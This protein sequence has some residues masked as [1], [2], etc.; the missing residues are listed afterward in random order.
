MKNTF[1]PTRADINMFAFD[2]DGTLLN[3]VHEATD[4]T[5][6]ALRKLASAGIRVVLAT[7][8]RYR[9]ALPLADMFQIEL[10]LVTASG[11]LVKS[12]GDHSTRFIAKFSEG[13]LEELLCALISE[14]HEPIAYTD[15]YLEGFDFYCRSTDVSLCKKSGV[16]EYLHRNRSLARVSDSFETVPPAGIFAGFAMGDRDEML[17][18][19]NILRNRWPHHVSLHTIRSPRYRDWMCEFAPAGVTKWSAVVDVAKSV[20]V[21]IFPSRP[22]F[23]R[24]FYVGVQALSH[25]GCNVTFPDQTSEQ[26]AQTLQG[27]LKD[28]PGAWETF[29]GRFGRLFA[30]VVDR[31][32]RSRGIALSTMEQEESVAEILFELVR[33]DKVVLRSFAGRSSLATPTIR[34]LRWTRSS[35]LRPIRTQ[36]E[37]ADFLPFVEVTGFF[38]LKEFPTHDARRR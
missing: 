5:C 25:E 16:E 12:P 29:V 23:E 1:F 8:R 28:V 6:E 18:L 37:I 32:A 4:A 27:C 31:T 21:R 24:I 11:A 30:W 9:D 15:S 14:G 7:G 35:D 22:S 38:V 19:E 20:K 13:V 17:H 10:P 34:A 26:D 36:S 3:S 2:I 33:N